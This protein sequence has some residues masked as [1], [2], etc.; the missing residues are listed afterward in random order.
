[1]VTDDEFFIL[2]EPL[3]IDFICYFEKTWIGPWNRRKTQ[4]IAPLFNI[5]LWNCFHSVLEDRPKTNNSCEGFHSGFAG[6]LGASHPTIYKFIS[7]L[8]D[9]RHL[10]RSK[11]TSFNAGIATQQQQCVSNELKSN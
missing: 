3:L 10:P 9:H 5:N 4:K 8:Q 2:N 6:L 11:L 1:L 7:G